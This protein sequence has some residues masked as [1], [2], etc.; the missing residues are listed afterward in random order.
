MT[1]LTSRADMVRIG[2]ALAPTVLRRR[3]LRRQLKR[4]HGLRSVGP[5][6]DYAIADNVR[7]GRDCRLGGPAYI[8]GSTIGDHSY[9]EVGCRISATD[10]GRFCAVAPYSF[11]G[12]AEHPTRSFVSTH[13]MFY[14]RLPEHGYD[15]IDEDIHH[16]MPRTRVGNDVW[17]GAGVCI[18][19]G[20]EIGDGAVVGAGAVVTRDIGPYEVHAGVPARRIRQRF[21]DD[22]I[23]FLLELKWWDQGTDWIRISA[24][25]MRDVDELRRFVAEHPPPVSPLSDRR[26]DVAKH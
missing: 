1:R 16:E 18:K 8:S 7:F 4:R 25:A 19:S 21:D 15:L 5:D 23:A 9:I 11:I 24:G 14:R 12:L 20:I 17:V 26:G 13:P 3:L 10:M 6:L 2:T 22:T